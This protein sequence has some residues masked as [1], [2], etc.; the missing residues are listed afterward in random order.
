MS[1]NDVDDT[2]LWLM[3]PG[4]TLEEIDKI[5]NGDDDVSSEDTS[6]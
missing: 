5:A 2:E 1:K 6:V 4:T 3:D